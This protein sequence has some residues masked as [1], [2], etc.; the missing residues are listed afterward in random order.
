MGGSTC[1]SPIQSTGGGRLDQDRQKDKRWPFKSQNK[2]GLKGHL[3][4]EE[5]FLLLRV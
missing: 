4:L 2:T 1:K 5:N 3:I